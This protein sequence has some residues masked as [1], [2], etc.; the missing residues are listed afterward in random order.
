MT[1]GHD[2]LGL[3]GTD[4]PTLRKLHRRLARQAETRRFPGRFVA[5]V[6]A[7]YFRRLADGVER[8]ETDRG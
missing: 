1:D 2:P 7:A 4:L 5:R 3:D 8:T 6:L